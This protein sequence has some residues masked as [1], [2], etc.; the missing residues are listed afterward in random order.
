MADGFYTQHMILSRAAQQLVQV[1][2]DPDEITT[3]FDAANLEYDQL[4]LLAS[5]KL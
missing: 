3:R 4:V 1:I 5:E 2:D